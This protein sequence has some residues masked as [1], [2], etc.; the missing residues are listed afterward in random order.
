M[1]GI[2]RSLRILRKNWKLAA[3]AILSL[4]VAMAVAVICLG[5]SNTAVLAPPAGESPTRLVMVYEQAAGNAV[6]HISYADFEYYRDNNHVFDG[7]AALAEEISAARMGF[8]TPGQ[9]QRPLVLVSS[10][11]V[12]ENYFSVLRLRPFLGRLFESGDKNPKS[13]IAVMTYSC[14]QRLGSDR[15]VVGK[16]IGS[17][18]IIGVTPREFTGSMFGLNGDLLV[19]LSGNDVSSKRDQR[20]LYLL[21]RLKAGV[22]RSEAQADLAVLSRQLVAAYPKEEVG[23]TALVSRA[24]LLPPDAISSAELASGVLLAFALFVLLIACA[25][26]ANLLLVIAVGRRQE[27]AIKLALGVSRKRLIRDFLREGAIICALSGA[28]GYALAAVTVLRYSHLDIDVPVVGVYSFALKI[29]FDGLV[30]VCTLG[31]M[32]VAMLATGLPAALYASSP[33]LSQVLGGEV[34]VGGTRKAIRRNAITVAQV[35]ICTTVLVGM[36]LCVRSLHNLRNADP[37]FA[38]RNIVADVMFPTDEGFSE[39]QGRSL[40]ERVREGVSGIAGVESVAL[41]NNLPLF[42]TGTTPVRVP[43]SEKPIPVGTSIIDD[44][45]FSTF[46]IPLIEGRVFRRSDEPSNQD[47]VVVNQGMAEKFWPGQ[48]PLGRTLITG[49]PPRAAAVIGVVGNVAY[50]DVGDKARPH[51]Y[52]ALSQHYDSGVS[53]IARTKGDPRLWTAPIGEAVRKAGFEALSTPIT[54]ENIENLSLLP[55]RV[56]AGFASA[57][58]VLGLLLAIVGLFGAISYSVSERRKELGI[59]VALGARPWQLMKMV[60]RQTLLVS[61]SGVVAGVLLGV[62]ITMLVRSQLYD[63]ST[64]EWPVLVPV[65]ASMVGISLV[66]AYLSAQPWLKVDPMEAVRHS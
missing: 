56:V 27:A 39:Q 32:L 45:Y 46:E 34:A 61:G 58:S 43:G 13:P 42:S 59:R 4:S 6:D 48:D 3:I 44:N 62:A 24:S 33:N 55:Q 8:G 26:V 1:V 37:G 38:T 16:T 22:S 54:F 28:L 9:S 31:L 21:A 40:Y 18:T 10:N 47:V 60:F 7:T 20:S 57:L 64:V 65:V 63:I 23:R 5:I 30:V 41:S 11:P 14:W 17:Y 50:E 12:S 25:N 53:V 15:Y 2:L 35:A 36:G 51:L 49:D 29:H 66:V 52:Y 19:P